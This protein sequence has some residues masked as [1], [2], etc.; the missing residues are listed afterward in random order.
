MNIVDEKSD[1]DALNHNDFGIFERISKVGLNEI[2]ALNY[3]DVPKDGN[4][5]YY[6]LSLGLFHNLDYHACLQYVIYMKV[7][8]I[9]IY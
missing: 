7:E 5:L 8:Q 6:S 1:D 4:C 9:Q 2:Q 3:I